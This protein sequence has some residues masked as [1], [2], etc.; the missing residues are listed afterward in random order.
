M[1]P[2]LI[3]G[4]YILVNKFVYKISDPKRGDIV[5]FKRDGLDYVAR[6]VSLPNENVRVYDDQILINNFPINES[7]AHGKINDG[8]Y[9]NRFKS[10]AIS[11]D[12][13]VLIGD[14]RE[15]SVDSRNYG[16][17]KKSQIVGKVNYIL[18]PTTRKGSIDDPN[19]SLGNREVTEI[20]NSTQNTYQIPQKKSSIVCTKFPS[21]LA[22]RNDGSY[23][24]TCGIQTSDRIDTDKSYCETSE[25]NKRFYF[26]GFLQ[27]NNFGYTADLIGVSERDKISLNIMDLEGNSV[28][29]SPSN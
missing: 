15:R 20:D 12:S 14:N 1:S 28:E 7:Y 29:C 9:I 10:Y 2:A 21:L 19:I 5:I 27:G 25:T 3:N 8:Q 11:N 24:S 18:W 4:D 13:Y 17:I 23:I 22:K 16:E 26:K 6:V